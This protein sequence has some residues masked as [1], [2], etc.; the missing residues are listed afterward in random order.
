MSADDVVDGI[1]VRDRVMSALHA[2]QHGYADV[3]T[4][5]W[6]ASTARLSVSVMGVASLGPLRERPSCPPM[7]EYRIP[8]RRVSGAAHSLQRDG[9]AKQVLGERHEQIGR[10][11]W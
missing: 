5:V 8:A 9:G 3:K 11:S 6:G 10:A 7:C 1:S 4:D 2:V